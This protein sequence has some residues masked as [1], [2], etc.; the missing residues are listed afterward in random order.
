MTN[1]QYGGPEMRYCFIHG[2]S[3]STKGCMATP[4]FSKSMQGLISAPS[5]GHP[6]DRTIILHTV[7]VCISSFSDHTLGTFRVTKIRDN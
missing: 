5:K 1:Y 2:Q 3:D 4:L 7:A 6:M